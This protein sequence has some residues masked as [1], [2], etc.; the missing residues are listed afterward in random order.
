MNTLHQDPLVL[1]EFIKANQKINNWKIFDQVHETIK[2][3]RY[4]IIQQGLF[5]P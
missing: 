5:L 4:V 2:R 3:T 1:I